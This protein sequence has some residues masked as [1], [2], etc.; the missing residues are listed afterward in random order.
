M[1]DFI[2]PPAD[3]T[4]QDFVLQDGDSS[5]AHLAVRGP[6]DYLDAPAETPGLRFITLIDCCVLYSS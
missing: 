4:P 1:E 2:D 5:H 6:T 3:P